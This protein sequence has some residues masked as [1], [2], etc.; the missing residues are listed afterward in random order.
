MQNIHFSASDIRIRMFSITNNDE[1]LS[2]RILLGAVQIELKLN[3]TTQFACKVNSIRSKMDFC[4]SHLAQEP[5]LR[6]GRCVCVRC[7][8]CIWRVQKCR[9]IVAPVGLS[10]LTIY[11][12]YRI[13]GAIHFFFFFIFVRQCWNTYIPTYLRVCER[14]RERARD[15]ILLKNAEKTKNRMQLKRMPARVF[16]EFC[17]KMLLCCCCCCGCFGFHSTKTAATLAQILS[18]SVLLLLLCRYLTYYIANT[19]PHFQLFCSS[20]KFLR[21]LPIEY[22]SHSHNHPTMDT[23]KWK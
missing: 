19:Y 22:R 18:H 1:K 3:G 5:Q 8:C 10:S 13:S 4:I 16:I 12:H 17:T 11:A 9:P 14:A 7:V 6:Y 20:A 2:N 23:P 15:D 21:T